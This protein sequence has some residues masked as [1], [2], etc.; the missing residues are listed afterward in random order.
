MK[1]EAILTTNTIINLKSSTM[2]R[3]F[4]PMLL[5]MLIGL[6]GN[7]TAS[8]QTPEPS[9]QWKFD[10]PS[11]L[12]AATVGNVTLSPVVLGSA[13]VSPATVGEAGIV[14]AEGPN[15]S[16]AI[17]VPAASALKVERAEGAAASMSFSFMIDL[18]VPNAYVYDGLF[19][20]STSNANDGEF[21]IS[22]SQIGAN[23]MGGYYGCIW[24]DMWYRVVFTNANGLLKLYVN[25]V[26]LTEY[27]TTNTRWEI[28]P[29]FYLL[30]DEDGETS[31]TYVSEVTFWE[32][33]LT[34][35]EAI[36]LGSAETLPWITDA[37]TIKDGDQ[38]YIISDRAKFNGTKSGK[39][40]AIST[41][42]SNYTTSNWGEQY[43]YWG[44]L[45]KEA[46][47]F[48]WTAEK[49]GDQW[50][51]LNKENNKYIGNM[52]EGESDVIFSD[53]PVG[54][55]L[56]DLAEGAG[57]FYMTNE[58]SEHSLHVQGYLRSDRASNSLAKQD[59]GDDDYDGA[60]SAQCG[61]PGRWRLL[62]LN[63]NTPDP[64][65]TR[66]KIGTAAEFEAFVQAV[67]AGETTI[68]AVLTA[69]IELTGNVMV[70][71][72]T[73]QYAGTF[74]GAEHTVKYNYD[75]T[76]NYCGLFAYVN[77]ATIRNLKVEG[78]VVSTAIHFG[79][80][81]G[82]A[83]GTVLVENVITNVD[84]T[85]QSTTGVQGDGGMLGANYA[86]ITFNNCAVL[87]PMGYPSS[88]MYSPFSAWSHGNSSVTL[89]NCFAACEFKDGT[90]IDGNSA[91]LTHGGTN[92]NLLNNCYYLNYIDKEQGTQITAEQIASGELCYKLNGDQSTIGW[93]QN[94]D[95]TDSYP[96]P[97]SSHARVYANGELKCDGTSAGG[98]LVY[99]NSA[100]ST[101][102]P[103]TYVDG[104]CT[105]C[106][107]W[108]ANYI[109]ADSEGFFN[110]GT[111][112]ELAWYAEYLAQGKPCG[113]VRLT[114]DIDLST[115]NYPDLMIASQATPF[116]GIFDGQE[117]TITYNYANVTSS[118]QGLFRAVN[119][120]TI[121]NL[122]V[123]GSATST[124]I[125][126]GALMG[127]AAGTVLVENV[128][129]NVNITGKK[130]G[131]TGD[132]G[133]VGAN[134]AQL[135]FN[136]CATLG[137]MGYEGTSMYSSYSGWSDGNSSTTLNNCYTMCKL[138]D[139]TG[140]GNCF[141]LTHGSGTNTFNNC[142]YLN[143]IGTV[144][145]TLITENMANGE[146]CYKLNGDQSVIGW[147]Q[148]LGTDALPV[149]F[150]SHAQVYANGTVRCDGA[151]LPDSPIV[152]SN[153]EGQTVR[154]DHQY[155]E[156]GICTVCGSPRQDAD[157]YYLID[158]AQ[159]LN[160]FATK[161]G[162]GQ[163][164]LNVLLTADIDLS[165][166]DYPDLMIGTET[167]EYAGIFNGDGHTITYNYALVADKWR[168]LFAFVN[169]ATIRN[170]YVEGSAVVTNIHY[171]ALIGRAYGT[172]L[173]E[174]VITNVN[175]TGQR[176]GVTGD[177]GML[178]ANYA[179]ITFNN[180]ATLGEMGYEGSS[181]Y[182]SFSAWSNGG[183]STTLNNCYSLCK[184]TEGT[185]TGNCFTL[186]HQSG[187]NTI[188]N[189]YYLNVIGKVIAGDQTQITDEEVANGS[190]AAKLG[191]GW[192]QNIGEDAYPVFDKTHATVKEITEAGY[193]TMY[194]PATVDV[195]T[196]VEV[197]TGEFEE[198]WLKLNKVEGIVPSWEPVV[199]KGA[200]GFYGFKPAAAAEVTT[201]VVFADLGFENAQDLGTFTVGGL[202]FSF[203]LGTNGT[204]N[205][206][207]Y[208][209]SG[210][211]ARVYA[212]N[213]M[214]ISASGAITKI[215]FTFG[216]TSYVPKSGQ[217]E[218]S[219]GSYT[220]ATKTWTGETE[221]LTVT[222]TGT[223]QWRIVSMTITY[224]GTPANIAG[225]VL[226]GA[227]EDT[228]AAGKYILAKPEGKPVGFYLANDGK[229]KA[230]KAYLE[231][232]E[233]TEVKAF[234]FAEDD[235]TSINEELRMKNEEFNGS[236]IYNL[237][238][239]RISKMQKGINIVNGKKVL[240]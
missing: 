15:G 199:L 122:K 203:D 72:S 141:T 35:E 146:F 66:T 187:T 60:N 144:Q 3:R 214:T 124:N 233:D 127:R 181:M 61:Y 177:G 75:I 51:F 100:T 16:S 90:V 32:T 166:S 57:K 107:A 17:F 76:S 47:G 232:P 234:Y 120:A 193:A 40:K 70:G 180:C 143:E 45:N 99:S 129:T 219:D 38:F 240:Y 197:F 212:G 207:K 173:V 221:S 148:T 154:P 18:K 162:D 198:D 87:G 189:C 26:K 196:G 165:T 119:G 115:S 155:G 29:V 110:I 149:P 111:V 9:G 6:T 195:P 74:D 101:V 44:D 157:G 179:N 190:L 167:A 49:V 91:T 108:D 205:T 172:V 69:D 176:S 140:T 28:D 185:G 63:A 114:A 163:T 14:E 82:Q 225:N 134:Y 208:Y 194:I 133:M 229:I 191:N 89:N 34:D 39:P 7:L 30:A 209:T 200:P 103:H 136:N 222:N 147:Y 168:G 160:W 68:D 142:Y 19:Q 48:V 128:V 210:A 105:V 153:T 95:G 118:H 5:L 98:E 12:M 204:G 27:E 186:T 58:E 151:E 223:S 216:G 55:T 41:Y 109:T 33:P 192:Y 86:N 116:T 238:G 182:S 24:D 132:A 67:N 106:G 184:L 113:N 174:N 56:T 88:S 97:F 126:F 37:S 170:L 81:I 220:M 125:H 96:V 159:K 201:E 8:A 65:D 236:A 42:Q 79:A 121:R 102:P 218:F 139:G 64:I 188:N 130:S 85:G 43:V 80:L 161:T 215:E 164:N 53:A 156:D 13:S 211:A 123:E 226:K 94:L 11:D 93:Y 131:V 25:G 228:E 77:G 206:P 84:I 202:T 169:G 178:G 23:A 171:G 138:T 152:Y 231:A 135:T 227:A 217:Y 20:T 175:I 1:N 137:T 150:A 235:A 92:A 2:K 117:H 50:A 4:L 54:Y 183:S 21:F 224:T 213:T 10:N 71:T 239:Q 46:D 31:D 104:W 62:K 36:A 158:T 52:N 59:V 237:A 145:G 83:N 22:K 73:N 230:G 112:A 78:T